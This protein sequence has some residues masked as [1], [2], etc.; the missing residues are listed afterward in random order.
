MHTVRRGS[1]AAGPPGEGCRGPARAAAG[2]DPCPIV[3]RAPLRLRRARVQKFYP[4]I[5]PDTLSGLTTDT[6]YI[7]DKPSNTTRTLWRSSMNVRDFGAQGDGVADDT[8]A[9]ERCAR[10]GRTVQVP[11]GVY[12]VTRAVGLG[13]ARMTGIRAA[14]L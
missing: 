9:F 5:E 12:R 7:K 11:P 8:R 4:K 3:P 13:P 1:V 6:T 14:G 10:A 2:P